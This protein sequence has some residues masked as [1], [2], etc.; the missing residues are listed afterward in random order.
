MEIAKSRTNNID[1]DLVLKNQRSI[2]FNEQ[3]YDLLMEELIK[4]RIISNERV[5]IIKKRASIRTK[6]H[7]E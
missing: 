6:E 5:E 4:E 1:K 3:L 7:E 2:F